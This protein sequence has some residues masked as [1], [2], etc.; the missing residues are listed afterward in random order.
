MGRDVYEYC[1]GIC[2]TVALLQEKNR[3]GNRSHG[4]RKAIN[5]R[6]WG[7][8]G[9]PRGIE[10]CDEVGCSRRFPDGEKIPGGYCRG[11]HAEMNAIVNAAREGIHI[12]GATLFVTLSPCVECAKHILNSGLRRVVW[13]QRYS[14]CF[15]GK[16]EET[17]RAL[18]L[19]GKTKT[20]I[21]LIL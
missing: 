21:Q 9:P 12:E 3:S 20:S 8:N 14:D 7:Y 5:S 1:L 2:R 17:E 19:I 10:H 18:G 11:A 6:V 15:S 13:L 16:E 4:T